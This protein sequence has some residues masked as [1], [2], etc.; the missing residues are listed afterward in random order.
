MTEIAEIKT[1]ADGSIDTT[2]YM[3]VGRTMRSQQAHDLAKATSSNLWQTLHGWLSVKMIGRL[4][5][6][7]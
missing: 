6:H 5:S 1:R 4:S 7:T 3:A 2:Y